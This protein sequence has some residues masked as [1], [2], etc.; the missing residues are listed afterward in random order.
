MFRPRS[1]L[2]PRILLPNARLQ[3]EFVLERES[4]REKAGE[5]TKGEAREG[6]AYCAVGFAFP[7]CESCALGEGEE[8]E[9]REEM[10][11]GYDMFAFSTGIKRSRQNGETSTSLELERLNSQ[12]LYQHP[13]RSPEAIN[14]HPSPHPPNPHI[15]PSQ[16][17]RNHCTV[18]IP[19]NRKTSI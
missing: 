18:L 7:D 19:T 11:D 17:D 16:V 5:R 13:S 3:S 12:H 9:E 14:K 6:R 1:G 15:V 4:W 10:H 8:G 2:C